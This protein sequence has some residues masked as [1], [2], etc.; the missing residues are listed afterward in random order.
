MKDHELANLDTAVVE[1]IE[2]KLLDDVRDT[3]DRDLRGVRS[4]FAV[5]RRLDKTPREPHEVEV[6]RIAQYRLDRTI[7]GIDW[8]LGEEWTETHRARCLPLIPL[9]RTLTE[10][11]AALART[12][13][14]IT[15]AMQAFR[16][17]KRVQKAHGIKL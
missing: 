17:L 13:S 5:V 15:R 9:A 14:D 10:Q 7:S 12:P 2:Q 3:L 1:Q 4:G 8:L 11:G 16:H 6:F